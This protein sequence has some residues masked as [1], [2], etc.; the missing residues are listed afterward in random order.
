VSRFPVDHYCLA[1][2]DRERV[3]PGGMIRALAKRCVWLEQRI[4]IHAAQG[5][6]HHFYTDELAAIVSLVEA[7]L[8]VPFFQERLITER[9][10]P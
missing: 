4:E 9:N 8:N 6:A 7:Q 10:R 3:P 1:L 2:R 5:K